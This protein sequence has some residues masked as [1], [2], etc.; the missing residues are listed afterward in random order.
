VKYKNTQ[1]AII[2][3]GGKESVPPFGITRDFTDDE[4]KTSPEIRAAI[5][6]K[7]LFPF[8]G[9]V[10]VDTP[11]TSSPRTKEWT[12]APESTQGKTVKKATSDGKG[13]VE[14]I[15]AEGEGCDG[16]GPADGVVTAMPRGGQQSTDHIERGLD[17]SKFKNASEAMDAEYDKE[18][19]EA[20]FDDDDSLSEK[21]DDRGSIPDADQEI[22]KDM[23]QVLV[24]RGRD[25]A[26]LKQVNE[27]IQET[28]TK[29]VS[30]LEQATRPDF[31]EGEDVNAAN[32]RIV[33]F[34]SQPFSSKKWS[35]SK[36][37]D[38]NFLGEI[39][40]ITKSDNLRS[41]V[42]QRLSELGK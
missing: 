23:S 22:I 27:I 38:T 17:A 26:E 30:E 37:T 13:V 10:P 9:A 40:R 1:K 12:Q 24:N 32:G 41:L 3:L 21:E 42:D 4:V 31:D 16:I 33:D 36:E 6:K 7:Y 34:L 2:I 18:S 11:T 8:Q 20:S 35:V 39:K 5:E 28:T 25:G 14:Y 19:A 15:I 29:A